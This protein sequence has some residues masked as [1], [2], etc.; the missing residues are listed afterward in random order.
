MVSRLA[1]RHKCGRTFLMDGE[2]SVRLVYGIRNSDDPGDL[3]ITNILVSRPH[4]LFF[5]VPNLA[6]RYGFTP[7]EEAPSYLIRV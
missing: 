7:K 6:V 2:Q 3:N 4:S 1:F 5:P